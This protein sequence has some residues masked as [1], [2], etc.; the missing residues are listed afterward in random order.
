MV[1]ESGVE[2][3]CTGSSMH[4]MSNFLLGFFFV[5][6]WS[7][8]QYRTSC[9]SFACSLTCVESVSYSLDRLELREPSLQ[10]HLSQEHS[11]TDQQAH[12]CMRCYRTASHPVHFSRGEGTASRSDKPSLSCGC[13]WGI[14][15]SCCLHFSVHTSSYNPDTHLCPS[16][17]DSNSWTNLPRACVV[18]PRWRPRSAW[19]RRSATH[20]YRCN[21]V[22]RIFS[23]CW[24]RSSSSPWARREKSRGYKAFGHSRLQGKWSCK[25]HCFEEQS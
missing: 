11:A 1:V 20:C 8:S 9:R 10:W 16:G 2:Q 18:R 21:I 14:G 7:R 22:F 3:L 23:R 24:L 12:H 4:H 15:R 13:R 25:V 6:R 5:S 19:L 17:L